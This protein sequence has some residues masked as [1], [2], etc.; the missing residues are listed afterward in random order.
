MKLTSNSQEGRILLNLL[1]LL[2]YLNPAFNRL[3]ELPSVLLPL[4]FNETRS[5]K[6]LQQIKGLE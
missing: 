6:E 1:S 5:K 2:I 4:T 3:I